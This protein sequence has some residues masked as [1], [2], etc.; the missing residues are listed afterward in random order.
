VRV[1]RPAGA[2]LAQRFGTSVGLIPLSEVPVAIAPRL[3]ELRRLSAPHGSLA[4]AARADGVIVG[5]F[6]GEEALRHLRFSA[7]GK[8]ARG[9]AEPPLYVSSV[10]ELPPF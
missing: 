5:L 7:A 2:E 8:V 6:D 10:E 3:A 4:L 9:T 1:L